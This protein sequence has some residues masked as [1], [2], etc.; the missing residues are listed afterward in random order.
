MAKEPK[1]DSV[2]HNEERH[3]K[4][5]AE[6]EKLAKEE[7]KAQADRDEKLAVQ[8]LK[9]DDAEIRLMEQ[10]IGL[11][12]EGETRDEL[13]ERVRQMRLD[14]A[15]EPVGPPPPSDFMQ[16]QINIEQECG[17]QAVKKAEEELAASREARE[18]AAAEEKARQGTMETVHMPN[19]GQDEQYPANKATLG[20]IK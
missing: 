7:A 18:K 14:Q 2:T 10:Q 3:A 1:T 6:S 20:K 13:L 17:R 5:K 12:H 19:P 11:L 9:A 15:A 8:A 4:L 16:Q